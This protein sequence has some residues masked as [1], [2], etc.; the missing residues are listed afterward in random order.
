M[1]EPMRWRMFG[2]MAA[3]FIAGAI[4]GAAVMS[5]NAAGSQTLKVGRTNEIAGLNRQKLNLNLDLSPEQRE[6]FEPLI[7]KTSEELEAS[8]LD[9]LKRI[10]DALARMHEQL[11]PDLTPDQLEKLKQVEADRRVKMREKY[12]YPPET[13][14]ADGH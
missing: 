10:S 7:K 8:H 11:K 2:Y 3:L 6:K 13:A 5:R 4:S 9:C 14:K 12:N 1:N